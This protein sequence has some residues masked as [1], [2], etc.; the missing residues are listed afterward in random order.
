MRKKSLG[1][2]KTSGNALS[3]DQRG[4]SMN[5]DKKR[6]TNPNP[7]QGEAISSK[8]MSD[9]GSVVKMGIF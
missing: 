9:V 6:M 1:L 5:R 7:N 4:R 8:G 2:A 3:I